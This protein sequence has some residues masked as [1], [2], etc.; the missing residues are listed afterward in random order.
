M[1][2]SVRTLRLA[3]HEYEPRVLVHPSREELG[4]AAGLQAAEKLK[5]ALAQHG[6]ARLM[7]AAAASQECTLQTLA[8]D[9]DVDWASVECF[10]MDEYIGL[11]PSAPQLFGNWLQRTFFDRLPDA[12][13]FHRIRS[14][15]D[16]RM[17]AVGYES[18]LGSWPFDLVL[19]GLGVN[20]HLAFNDPPADLQDRRD[21][22][23]VELDQASRRQQCDEGHF[24]TLGE[25][26]RTAITVTIPRVLRAGAVIASV[27]GEHKRQAVD[28][29]LTQPIGGSHPGTA[30]RTHPDVTIHLDT[31]SRPAGRG[32]G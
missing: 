25:V 12:V 4:R 6:T 9:P 20:G 21:V 3:G 30:L 29:T 24:A 26:P 32:I 16:P 23:L 28:G 31:D 17:S 27:P 8:A 15:G 1:T 22:R 5:A 2:D 11:P 13:T 7:L 19:L 10:H 18:V 14:E